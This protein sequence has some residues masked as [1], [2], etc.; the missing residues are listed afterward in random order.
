MIFYQR[1]FYTLD[2]KDSPLPNSS[3][4]TIESQ[5]TV[6]KTV[7]GPKHVVVDKTEWKLFLEV[8]SFGS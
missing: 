7:D 8:V 6:D 4:Y 5:L 1:I 3:F 2:V